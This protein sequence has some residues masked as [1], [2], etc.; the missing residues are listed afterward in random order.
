MGRT[1]KAAR[2]TRPNHVETFSAEVP[3]PRADEVLIQVKAS[4]ICGTDIHIYRGDY[5]GSYPIIPGHEFAGIITAAGPEVTRFKTGDHA[6]V[7]PNIA[8]GN[9]PACLHNRQN[10]CENW[11]AVGVLQPGAMAEYV[12]APEK[13]VFAIGSLSFREGAFVEPLSCVLHG[14][15][16]CG[17]RMADRVLVIG[18]GPIGSL[19]IQTIGSRG[20]SDI[21]AVDR[22]PARLALAARA[23]ASRTADS[24]DSLEEMPMPDDSDAAAGGGFDVVVD[25]T[26]VPAL[27]ARTVEY[28]R[29][30][31]RILLFGVPPRDGR[32]DLPA[33]PVF[34]KGLSIH[35]SFTSVR[36]SFQAVR[37]LQS[38]SVDVSALVSHVLPLERFA[39]GMEMI[40]QGKDGVLKVH[41]DPQQ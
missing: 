25:A 13:N 15:E 30:G 28:A 29:P 26:G 12:L 3:E 18:A 37:M 8:C 14:V 21:T 19:L 22:N 11:G 20:A 24:L 27:M 41:I 2:I 36:N 32:L 5:L 23:G 10:F 38:K 35:S 34:R 4:G 17:V 9:C 7:E 1:M 33:F 31:G 16:R 40:E 6:A 39:E